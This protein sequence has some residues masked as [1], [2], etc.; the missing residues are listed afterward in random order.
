MQILS[1]P[2]PV[3]RHGHRPGHALEL[4]EKFWI[5]CRDIMGFD[6]IRTSHTSFE[7]GYGRSG[8][9]AQFAIG[10]LRLVVLLWIVFLVAARRL[11]RRF[12][13]ITR[14]R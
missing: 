6:Q 10:K 2:S 5:G 11:L 14:R 9:V 4:N 13:V 8:R 12:F 7:I 1:F 3:T